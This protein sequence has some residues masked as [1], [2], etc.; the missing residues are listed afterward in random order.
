DLSGYSEA[1]VTDAER[2]VPLRP[3]NAAYVIFTSGSTGRPKGV[4]V[5]QAAVVNQ[6]AWIVGEYGIGAGDVVLFKT[7][8]TFDVSV[9]ELFAPLVVGA[10]MVVAESD[11]HRD[12]QYL[13]R[14]IE[15]ER[16]T[17][18]SFVPSM[19][20]V[21]AGSVAENR[22]ALSSL[23]AL[24][25]AGEA[26]TGDVVAAVRRVGDVALFN[27]Y[28]PTE[29]TV[30][31]THGPVA[32]IVTGAVPIGSPVWNARA[33]VL[34]SRLH[35]VAPGVAGELYLAG[36]QLA[37][38]YAG[39]PDLTSDRF[40]AN[41]FGTGERMY[42]TGDLVV[43]DKNGVITYLGRTDF[44]VKLRGLRIELGEIAT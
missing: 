6:I 33:Y 27:L 18:T 5:S 9:W 13:A 31:A 41:P 24:F 4:V 16:V 22:V 28:G 40:V 39:R 8:A 1:P 42:R 12:P 23:R 19:L 35:P 38:G 34:D 7:P 17:M 43:R 2:V 14:V 15:G 21:F 32:D 20:S 25:V 44:Q 26:F 3:E 37:Q 10:R 29:F 36:V 11:G 30:H